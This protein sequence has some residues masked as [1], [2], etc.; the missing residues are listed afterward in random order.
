MKEGE[1]GL[2]D[3]LRGTSFI[4]TSFGKVTSMR[5]STGSRKGMIYKIG[6]DWYFAD[7]IEH[8]WWREL[9]A[10]MGK[11][12]PIGDNYSEYY[13]KEPITLQW[14]RERYKAEGVY[15]KQNYR[16]VCSSI[17]TGEV[18]EIPI[19]DLRDYTLEKLVRQY[20][21]EHIV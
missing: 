17:S 15:F 10:I 20:K 7:E 1:I 5:Q 4:S 2:G 3:I 19:Y 6:N 8:D 12:H 11:Q 13:Y 14:K 16:V 18:I 21:K 9:E